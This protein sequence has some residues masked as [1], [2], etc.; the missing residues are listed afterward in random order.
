[1]MMS[2]N[3]RKIILGSRSTQS[4]KECS[5]F[6]NLSPTIPITQVRGDFDY[7]IDGFPNYFNVDYFNGKITSLNGLDK[8]TSTTIINS[9]LRCYDN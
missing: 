4:S 6:A 7:T 8:M 1:M 2:G 9:S 5:E 3:I